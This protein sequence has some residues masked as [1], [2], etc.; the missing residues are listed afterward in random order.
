MILFC[1]F[2]LFIGQSYTD[3]NSPIQSGKGVLSDARYVKRHVT[4][5][6]AA[7]YTESKLGFMVSAQLH[8]V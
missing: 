4:E 3:L 1:M 2:Y 7:A 5:I 6:A 8:Y